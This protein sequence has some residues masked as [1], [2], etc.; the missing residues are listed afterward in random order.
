MLNPQDASRPPARPSK[1]DAE[2][3]KPASSEW[4]RPL[5]APLQSGML[6]NRKLDMPKAK[7]AVSSRRS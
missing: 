5:R 2:E 6:Q 7:R 1:R 3:R 4:T